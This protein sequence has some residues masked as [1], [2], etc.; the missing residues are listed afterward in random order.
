[1]VVTEA[2]VAQMKANQFLRGAPA[3]GG[4]VGDESRRGASVASALLTA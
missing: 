1:M 2:S 3:G 4:G